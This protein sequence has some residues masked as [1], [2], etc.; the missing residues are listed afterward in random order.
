MHPTPPPPPRCGCQQSICATR[1]R[2]LPPVIPENP[3]QPRHQAPRRGSAFPPPSSSFTFR[4]AVPR[5]SGDR[6]SFCPSLLQT[7][8]L[9]KDSIWAGKIAFLLLPLNK[10]SDFGDKSQ[11][12]TQQNH[13]C[14]R[15]LQKPPFVSNCFA[16]LAACGGS[17]L[18]A[19]SI[20]FPGEK[21]VGSMCS[22]G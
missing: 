10:Y 14:T 1:H 8:E 9:L 2:W 16:P 19:G 18:H 3:P 7:G 12:Q 17:G 11:R 6:K 13:G 4:A 5:H 22:G 20:T 21:Q 15:Q